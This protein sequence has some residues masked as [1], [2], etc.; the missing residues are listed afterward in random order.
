MKNSTK[1]KMKHLIDKFEANKGNIG[2][3]DCGDC[4]G[5]TQLMQ[6]E[7]NEEFALSNHLL[8]PRHHSFSSS[9]HICES[10]V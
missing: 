9:L 6:N 1:T 8:L 4:S 3:R 2:A 5:D 10:Q 7:L